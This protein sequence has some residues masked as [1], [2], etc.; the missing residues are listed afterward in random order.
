MACESGGRWWERVQQSV[1][2]CSWGIGRE[3]GRGEYLYIW[4]GLFHGGGM[5]VSGKRNEVVGERQRVQKGESK[6]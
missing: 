2:V 6:K 4:W 5:S 3:Q 1:T